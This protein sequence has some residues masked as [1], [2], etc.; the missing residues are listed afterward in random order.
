MGAL[1]VEQVLIQEAVAIHGDQRP[2]IIEQLR[3]HLAGQDIELARADK[4]AD[5]RSGRDENRDWVK[6]RKVF[7]CAL[8][9]LNRTALCFSGG[10]IRSATFCL[11]VI[12]ALAKHSLAGPPSSVG[13]P[14]AKPEEIEADA[15]QSLLSRFHFLSKRLSYVEGS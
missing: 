8:N 3:K 13:N 12:Q 10:G 15:N 1:S 6:N 11:G 7:Y 5:A 4:D 9:R 14:D 2:D